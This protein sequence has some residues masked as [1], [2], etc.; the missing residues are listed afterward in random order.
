[1][2]LEVGGALRFR[3]EAEGSRDQSTGL[4]Q[5]KLSSFQLLTTGY[6]LLYSLI[7]DFSIGSGLDVVDRSQDEK[8]GLKYDM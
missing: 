7:V 3:L 5:A 2:P 4:K 8:C 1:M 6:W